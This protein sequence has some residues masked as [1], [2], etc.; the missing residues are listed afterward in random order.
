MQ[1]LK[2]IKNMAMSNQQIVTVFSE[3]YYLPLVEDMFRILTDTLHKFAFDKNIEL[4]A[5]LLQMQVTELN[6]QNVALS[7][8][9][10]FQD[11]DQQQIYEFVC[12]LIA[13]SNNTRDFKQLIKDFLVFTRTFKLRDPDL[14][15]EKLDHMNQENQQYLEQQVLDHNDGAEGNFEFV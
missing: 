15:R 4:L 2:K 9:P 3:N 6:P 12:A 7:I 14:D 1:L 5:Y 11:K 13:K 10:L 8:I